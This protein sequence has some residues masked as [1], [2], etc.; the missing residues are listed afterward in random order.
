MRSVAYTPTKRVSGLQ[1]L[2][3]NPS[4]DSKHWSVSVLSGY[5]KRP[6][7]LEPDGRRQQCKQSAARTPCIY[8]RACPRLPWKCTSCFAYSVWL[9]HV[10]A[11]VRYHK[12]GREGEKRSR[13]HRGH[14]RGRRPRRSR[15]PTPAAAAWRRRGFEG[16]KESKLGL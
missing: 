16:R 3:S 7:H 10:Q 4:A 8:A 14:P 12:S 1:R 15:P 6:E 9:V 5:P 13:Y 2:H 11:R